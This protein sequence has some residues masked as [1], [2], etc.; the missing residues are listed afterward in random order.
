MNQIKYQIIKV[1]VSKAG[2]IKKFYADTDKQYKRITGI[3]LSL[4]YE[5]SLFGSTFSLKV[6][7]KEI[8]PEDFEVKML[9]CGNQVSPNDRFYESIDEEANGSRIEGKYTDGA[10][11]DAEYPYEMNI[12][13][14]L[15]E[16]ING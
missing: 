2:A 1:Q 12:Y 9:S 13:L 15:E 8:F 7:D 16:K 6:A 4:P 3:F 14:R 11:E 5:E 10:N